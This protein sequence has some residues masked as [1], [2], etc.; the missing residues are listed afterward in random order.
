[1]RKPETPALFAQWAS[2]APN[3]LQILTKCRLAAR[4]GVTAITNL[5]SRGPCNTFENEQDEEVFDEDLGVIPTPT[6]AGVG[7]Q[8]ESLRKIARQ[9]SHEPASIRLF[10]QDSGGVKRQPP[11]RASR[12]I[13]L[14]EREEVSRRLA[15]GLSIR[16]IGT[17]WACHP[18]QS[19]GR[20][21]VTVVA[22]CTAASCRM[23]GWFRVRCP[24][25]Q[26]PHILSS[27]SFA[28]RL[29]SPT[30]PTRSRGSAGLWIPNLDRRHPSTA[31]SRDPLDGG[32]LSESVP[33]AP[34]N[35]NNSHYGSYYLAASR[36]LHSF[37]SPSCHEQDAILRSASKTAR[38]Y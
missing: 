20:S 8:G 29:T 35:C 3:G 33:S 7:P 21:I 17:S 13:S 15:A 24:G 38:E 12:C 6:G 36:V 9:L 25:A 16:A 28:T 31:S 2:A 11:K 26:L 34:P 14:L 30:P 10:L 19:R 22:T 37:P 32:K 27:S 5:A 4:M 23:A 18:Q 1:M